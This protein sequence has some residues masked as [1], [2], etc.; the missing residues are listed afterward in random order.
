[1]LTFERLPWAITLFLK[2]GLVFWLFYR[3]N[4]RAYPLFFA[5][6]LLNL[7]QSVVLFE[8]YRIWGFYS[9][10]A[11]EIAWG[12][13]GLVSVTR[14]L[15]V[16]EI[17]HRI[18]EKYRGVW[19]LAWHLLAVVAAAISMY[20]LAVAKGN[21]EYG[22]LILDRGLELA[23]ATVIVLLFLF[24]RY[25]EVEVEAVVRT[26]AIGFFLYSC[27]RVLND[28]VL[29]SWLHRYIRVW[30]QLDML[31]FLAS[32]LVWSWALRGA[33]TRTAYEPAMLSPGM[34]HRMAPEI[35]SRLKS[36]NENLGHIGYARR[37]RT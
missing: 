8:S 4:H 16:A 25:Y 5:Y 34:Y 21:W 27:F 28:T 10:V 29:E 12:T 19:Q 30:N 3:K 7:I 23:I 1:M 37:K 33:Q 26:L 11:I 32:L 17:C 20:S 15:A 24:A 2:A 13:Q 18:L 6:T 35:N 31:A 14:A 22:I 36:L 9:R